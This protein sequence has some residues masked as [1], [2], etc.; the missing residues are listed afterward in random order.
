MFKPSGLFDMWDIS[1]CP[2]CSEAPVS[3]SFR[4]SFLM[5]AEEQ[6]ELKRITLSREMVYNV[7]RQSLFDQEVT[8]DR[9]Y[10]EPGSLNMSD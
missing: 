4:L 6:S 5:P 7:L 10:I 2:V 3:A 1:S 8:T 9:R